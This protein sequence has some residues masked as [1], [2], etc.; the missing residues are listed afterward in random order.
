MAKLKWAIRKTSIETYHQIE[1]EGLLSKM[2]FE[3]YAALFDH[4]PASS[5]ELAIHIE[6]TSRN[7]VATRMTELRNA[8]VVEEVGEK[9]CTVT[10]RNVITWDVTGNLPKKVDKTVVKALTPKEKHAA[11]IELRTITEFYMSRT[12]QPCPP[13]IARLG[14]WLVGPG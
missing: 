14:Q 7:N 9:V 6:G 8:G 2:R 11:V 1:A 10:G 3:V 5:G 4:G 12:N 13:S